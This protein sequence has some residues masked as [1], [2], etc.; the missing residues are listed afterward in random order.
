MMQG[1]NL[2]P[3]DPTVKGKN[4]PDKDKDLKP[5]ELNIGEEPF[6]K[7]FSKM[8]DKNEELPIKAEI[9]VIKNSK[10]DNVGYK[11]K[12]LSE[13]IQLSDH[14]GR[15]A[16]LKQI[17][18]ENYQKGFE[19]FKKITASEFDPDKLPKPEISELGLKSL[20]NE[21]GLGVIG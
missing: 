17:D 2:E 4:K 21:I 7:V 8:L 9:D 5:K 1:I 13:H 20:V 3:F 11:P 6:N 12:K 18:P 19:A 16:M 15:F 10:L 14:P